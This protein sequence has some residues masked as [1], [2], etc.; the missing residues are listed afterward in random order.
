ML[1]LT[2]PAAALDFHYADRFDPEERDR[3]EAWV[4]E[5]AAALAA[6]V[7]GFPFPV[8]VTFHRRDGASEPV[9]WA[10]TRRGRTQGVDLHVDPGYPQQDF[11]RDWTAPHELAHLVLPYLGR[12]HAWF[13]EGFASYLQYPVMVE[14]GV[15]SPAAADAAYRARIDRARSDFGDLPQP[16][17]AAAPRLRAEGRYPTLYWGG[18]AYFIEAD[19]RLRDAGHPGLVALLAD[20]L[21]C[22]RQP[23]AT[24]R[25]LADTLDRLSASTVFSDLLDAF[26]TQPGFPDLRAAD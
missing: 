14:M 15:M 20:Y 16:F 13:A 21:G 7:G 24:P 1:A 6:L 25:S 10:H 4:T 8:Q 19:A 17:A 18:A 12:R 22:C 2:A 26:E 5:T 11:R 23:R 3:L 9:P